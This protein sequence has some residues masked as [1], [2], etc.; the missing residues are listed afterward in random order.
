MQP[1]SP[2]QPS[3]PPRNR[4]ARLYHSRAVSG[5]QPWMWEAA[6]ATAD[7][8]LFFPTEQ[9]DPKIGEAKRVC[10]SCPVKAECLEYSLASK[11][12]SG[13]WGGLDEW[14]RHA[15]LGKRQRQSRIGT[16]GVA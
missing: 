6:C 7:P 5:P 9:R 10:A 4:N 3:R 1:G 13:V 15:L 16:Q 2:S 8:D 14:E 11:E 12:E